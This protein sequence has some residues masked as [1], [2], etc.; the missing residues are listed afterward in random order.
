M[1]ISK[2]CLVCQKPLESLSRRY[3]HHCARYLFGFSVV[4]SIGFNRQEL[5]DLAK[6]VISQQVTVP[7]VQEKLSL[8]QRVTDGEKRLTMVGLE[9]EFILKAPTDQYPQ[10]PE[11]EAATM[12]LARYCGIMTAASGLMELSD[13]TL[14][15]LTRR[16]DRIE[17]QE[18]H[19][20]DMCQLTGRLTEDKYKGSVEQ[21]AK[22]IRTHSRRPGFDLVALFELVLFSFLTGNGDMHLKNYLLLHEPEVHL[23]PAFDLLNT[24]LLIPESHDNEDSALTIN[25]KKRN[26]TINDMRMLSS[27]IGLT[28]KQGENVL[29]AYRKRIPGMLDLLGA[30][31]L[32]E[33][34]VRGYQEVLR[35]RSRRLYG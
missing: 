8:I 29:T 27:R 19:M 15:Y 25:G 1:T 26:I 23:A 24:R 31:H 32:S 33:D 7:G 22:V 20:E 17:G 28:E 18:L 34:Q 13:G 5:Q 4:P 35:A 9:G 2:R 30:S 12:V 14:V 10:L 6:R 3:H 16:F 11:N 21:I